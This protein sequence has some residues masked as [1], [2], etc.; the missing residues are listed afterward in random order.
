[1]N[2]ISQIPGDFQFNIPSVS[3]VTKQLSYGTPQPTSKQSPSVPLSLV[4]SKRKT[5]ETRD[6]NQESD[7]SCD[8]QQSRKKQKI[9]NKNITGN[10]NNNNNKNSKINN[11]NTKTNNGK[12]NNNNNKSID[13]SNNNSTPKSQVRFRS[14][15]GVKFKS[16][17]QD[18]YCI[19]NAGA[20]GE[21]IQCDNC[22]K[23]HHIQ[24]VYLDEQ[25]FNTLSNSNEKWFCPPC[26]IE[27][28]KNKNSNKKVQ[29]LNN[30]NQNQNS[31]L[32]QS[33][34]TTVTTIKNN[35]NIQSENKTG[36]NPNKQNQNQYHNHKS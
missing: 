31:C 23:W 16:K 33:S 13:N 6:L 21:M 10:N 30:N 25:K 18:N 32:H 2:I 3:S 11:N 1:M 15:K 12:T 35:N 22:D 4:G 36:D 20:Y 9:G 5:Y 26:F 8:F 17:L 28:N 19:C 14:T 27:I 7:E 24:C 29:Q 34:D